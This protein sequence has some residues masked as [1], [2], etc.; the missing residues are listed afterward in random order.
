MNTMIFI[1]L[2]VLYLLF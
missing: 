2:Y 1:P